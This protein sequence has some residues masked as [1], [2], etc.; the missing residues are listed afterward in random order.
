MKIKKVILI[1]PP[2]YMWPFINESDNFLLPLGLPCIAAA[3]RMAFPRI[4]VKIIDCPP[5]KTG[6]K[7]LK[8]NLERE[9]PDIV[10]A[11]EEALYQHEA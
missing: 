3:I 1:R 4:E 9:R 6:W 7:S 5:L 10:G 8:E 11:G 2:R